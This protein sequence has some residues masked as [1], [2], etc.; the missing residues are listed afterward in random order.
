MLPSGWELQFTSKFDV[1][2]GEIAYAEIRTS[3]LLVRFEFSVFIDI[4]TLSIYLKQDE[5]LLFVDAE[6]QWVYSDQLL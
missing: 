4:N 1:L 2:L 3:N 5:L 6:Q